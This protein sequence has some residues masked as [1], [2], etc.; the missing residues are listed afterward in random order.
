M[1]NASNQAT[2]NKIIVIGIFFALGMISNFAFA[3]FGKALINASKEFNG[4]AKG[5]AKVDPP[6]IPKPAPSMPQNNIDGSI[7]TKGIENTL[8]DRIPPSSPKINLE[9]RGNISG[10]FN[11]ASGASR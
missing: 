4:A 6:P 3:G 8:P 7:S 5:I 2:K 10:T 1:K 11:N 9:D